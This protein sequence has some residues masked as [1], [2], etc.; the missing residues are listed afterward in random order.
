MV[1]DAM[2]ASGSDRDEVRRLAAHG[3]P[4]AGMPGALLPAEHDTFR[5]ALRVAASASNDA[6]ID[7]VV[8]G[9]VADGTRDLSAASL[10]RLRTRLGAN[11]D[12]LL[13]VAALPVAV[14]Q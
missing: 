10:S 5:Q 3:W 1:A 7:R 9:M 6:A 14:S 8:A 13:V 4:P 11:Y 12:P 2:T